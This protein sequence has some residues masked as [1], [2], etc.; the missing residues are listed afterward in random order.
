MDPTILLFLIPLFFVGGFMLYQIKTKGFKGATFGAKILDSSDEIKLSKGSGFNGH[1][2]VHTLE[3]KGKKNIGIEVVQK[4][5]LSYDMTA[6]NFQR[7]DIVEL[8]SALNVALENTEQAAA[9]QRR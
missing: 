6:L 9:G 8:V 5:P 3:K 4:T 2:K 1:I 7:E